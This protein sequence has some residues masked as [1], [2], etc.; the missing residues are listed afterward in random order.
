MIENYNKFV[1]TI[2]LLNLVVYS[3]NKEY[4]KTSPVWGGGKLQQLDQLYRSRD[5]SHDFLIPPLPPPINSV[6]N[7]HDLQILIIFSKKY[8]FIIISGLQV[9]LG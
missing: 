9:R 3:F 8:L 7:I 2:I 5:F 6:H 4:I 1:M